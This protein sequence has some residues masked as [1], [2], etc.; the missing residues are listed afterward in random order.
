MKDSRL[1]Q[2]SVEDIPAVLKIEQECFLSS[3]SFEGYKSEL[4]RD[5]SK[6]IIAEMDGE[7]AG[8]AIARLITSV[9]EGEILNIAVSQKFRNRGLGTLLLKEINGFLKSEKIES[10]WLEVRKSNFTA[11]DFYRKNGFVLYGERKNF[12]TNPSEDALVM[13]LNL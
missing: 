6:A 4:L 3:W 10:V 2:M 13:K 8:F 12:Y 7:A 5:D 11:Q 9:N 1:R